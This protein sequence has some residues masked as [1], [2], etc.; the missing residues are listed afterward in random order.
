M[1]MTNNLDCIYKHWHSILWYVPRT[2]HQ[3][4]SFRPPVCAICRQF[5]TT[6][7]RVKWCVYLPPPPPPPPHF[8]DAKK[9]A[10]F[11]FRKKEL[12][13]ES[14]EGW[15]CFSFYPNQGCSMEGNLLPF[16]CLRHRYQSGGRSAY[17][18]E[19][20]VLKKKFVWFFWVYAPDDFFAGELGCGENGNYPVS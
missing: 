9:M 6:S 20:G 17:R 10:R 3:T 16:V 7:H 8:N 1:W 5:T 2:R 15:F 12:I 11:G 14:G 18:E 4:N 19:G 13:I